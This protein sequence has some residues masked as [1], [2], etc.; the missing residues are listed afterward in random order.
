MIYLLHVLYQ[1]Y[2]LYGEFVKVPEK[3]V[4]VPGDFVFK[5]P[6]TFIRDVADFHCD[7]AVTHWA[8]DKVMHNDIAH[9]T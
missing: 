1:L 7:V 9:L 2:Q 8:R 3:V 4:K 5:S 6:G